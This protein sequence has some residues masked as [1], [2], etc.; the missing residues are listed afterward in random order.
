MADDKLPARAL[1]KIFGLKDQARQAQ[2]VMLSNQRQIGELQRAIDINP[3]GDKADALASEVARLRDM[4]VPHQARHRGLADLVARVEHYLATLPADAEIEDTKKIKVKLK[5]ETHQQAIADLRLKIGKLIAERSDVERAGLP[6]EE[7]KAQA[8]KWI[9]TRAMQARPAITA[10]HDRFDVRF[11]FMDPTAFAP[12]LDPLALLCWFD[13]EHLETKLNE[14]IDEMPK[15]TLAL[16]PA[17][18][19]ER[20]ASLAVELAEAERLECALIEDAMDNGTIVAYRANV[21]PAAVLGIVV[22]KSK[23]KAA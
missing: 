14:L 16:T 15:P 4:Q 22:T 21:N 20:L 7:I 1:A 11:S 10:T 2:T 8:R 5:G 9:T 6:V 13:P 17:E 19:A 23:A 3:N 12:I 18:K